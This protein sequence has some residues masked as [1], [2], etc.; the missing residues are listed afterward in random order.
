[1]AFS[2]KNPEGRNVWY[3]VREFAMATI[4][5]GILAHGGSFHHV[6]TFLVFS[7]YL[8]SA[9]RVAALSKSPTTFIFTHD[10]IAVG[11]DG[12]THQPI[13][14]L[15]M[16]RSIPDVVVIRP[17]DANE[18]R[19]AWKVALE[20]KDKPVVIA[21]TRQNLPNLSGTYELEDINNGAYIISDSHNKPDG[22][23]IAT[24]SEV[25]LALRT[26]EILENSG[27]DI[28]VISM[29]SMELFK[30]SPKSYQDELLPVDVKNV[31]SIEMGTSFGWQ[32]FTGRDGLNISIDRFG[33]SGDGSR[34][35]EEFGFTPEKI[36][37]EYLKK[38]N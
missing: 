15:A 28:R 29:P 13:E 31:V 5:N 16:L 20:S 25:E 21:L 24:G 38:F 30:L 14:H 7:D 36:A 12:P 34:V 32:Q 19:L 22:I 26:K 23:L 3:G 33:I 11:E 6:S 18:V 27:K 35:A 17:A 1:M 9:L 8:K 10:S 2:D 37:K 4:A